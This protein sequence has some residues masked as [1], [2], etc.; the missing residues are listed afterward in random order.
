MVPLLFAAPALAMHD[1]I[2]P[3]TENLRERIAATAPGKDGTTPL[4]LTLGTAKFTLTGLIEVEASLTHPEGGTK[5]DDL[6]LSTVQLGLEAELTPWLG[7]HVIGLW[8]EDDTEPMAIDEA[9]L[10]LKTPEPVGGQRLSLTVGRQYLTFGKFDSRMISDPLTLD[11]GE[12]RSTSVV[13]GVEGELWAARLGTF[14]GSVDDGDANG[15]DTFVAALEVT[16]GEGFTLGVSYL[17]DLAESGAEL[18]QEESLYNDEVAGV[19]AF[20][21]ISH[22]DFGLSAEY[23][24]TIDTFAANQVAAGEELTGKR[25]RARFVEARWSATDR[26]ALAARYEKAEAYQGG[27]RRAGATVAYGLCD[28]AQFAVQYLHADTSGD[29]PVHTYTAQLALEF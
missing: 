14:V 4:S 3:A 7:G 11:L 2:Q 23:L 18:V 13:M 9:V 22:G 16:P 20:I 8:E 15:L 5:E 10:I 17:S 26:L 29:S 12:T 19:S 24:T 28:Y 27:V 25:P 6:R 21:A 1:T